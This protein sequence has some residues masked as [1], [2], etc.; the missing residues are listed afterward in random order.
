M[1]TRLAP[2]LAVLLAVVVTT[3]PVLAL[4]AQQDDGGRTPPPST[5]PPAH[6]GN[7]PAP[8]PAPAPAQKPDNGA[9]DKEP[10]AGRQE[11]AGRLVALGRPHDEAQEA[12]SRLTPADLEVLLAYPLMMQTAGGSDRVAWSIVIGL[13][14]FGGLL[15]LAAAGDGSLLIN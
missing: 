10:A 14:L 2:F 15:A 7:T 13:A 5:T 1:K 9:G 8:A 3:Q 11:I 4:D 6:S 12:A